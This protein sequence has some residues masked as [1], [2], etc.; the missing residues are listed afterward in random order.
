MSKLATL[1]HHRVNSTSTSSTSTHPASSSSPSSSESPSTQT[2]PP[3][4]S[5]PHTPPPQP[6]LSLSTDDSA[7]PV[8]HTPQKRGQDDNNDNSHVSPISL[9][10]LIDKELSQLQKRS[11]VGVAPV[12]GNS[13][14]TQW[15]AAMLIGTPQQEFSVVFD[16]GSSDL[17]VSSINCVSSACLSLRRFNPAR[18]K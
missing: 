1:N 13:L 12:R 7:H 18:S 10:D 9:L 8:I 11:Y 5:E 15:V 17:W 14:D 6:S 3:P 16:T 2:Q 4:A